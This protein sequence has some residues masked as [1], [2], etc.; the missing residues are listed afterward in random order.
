MT[1]KHITELQVIQTIAGYFVGTLRFDEN[2]KA[3][4]LHSR[5]SEYFSTR[6]EAENEL[7]FILTLLDDEEL[8]HLEQNRIDDM[9]IS[10][11][12]SPY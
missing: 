12:Q 2:V 4:Q 10:D 9:H 1:S 5:E 8:Y 6:R 11:L 7:S 3:F